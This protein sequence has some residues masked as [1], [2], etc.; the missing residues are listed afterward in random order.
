[1]QTF[2]LRHLDCPTC[3]VKIERGLNRMDG[4]MDAAIDFA[5]LTLRVSAGDPRRIIDAVGRIDPAVAVIPRA[6]HATPPSSPAPP[7][8]RRGIFLLTAAT[9]LFVVLLAGETL[10]A[11]G[12]LVVLQ[13]SVVLAAY[14]LAGWN[15]WRGA[16]HTIR[17]RIFFDENVL[18]VIATVGALIIGAHAEAVG[19]MIF[20]KAGELL[21]ERVLSRSRRA[22]R[23][24]LA[25]RPDLAVR[26][27]PA[28]PVAV[29]PET[30]NIGE[31]ILV[32]TGE[33][34]PL[35]GDVLTGR[36]QVDT[37]PLTGESRPR[38]VAPGD[39]VMAGQINRTGLLTVRVTRPF[40]QSSIARMMDLVENAVARK[41][42]TEQF[43]T[44]FA[45]YYTPAVVFAAA[46][47]A[48][49]PPLIWGGSFHAWLYRALVL[50]VISCPCALV[51]SIPLG[52]FGGIGN[53]S[54]QGIFFKGASFMDALA[55]LKTVVFD[56][57]GTLT[58]GVF[59]V[60]QVV[61]LNGY[62]GAQLL[63]FAAAAEYHA[64]H[65][66]AHSILT[67]FENAGG[68]LNSDHITA[69]TEL[70]GQGVRAA[71]QGRT[72]M[73]G[74]D[75][76]LHLRQIPHGRCDFD[77]TVAHIAVDDEYVGY[78]L[79]G[80][81]VKDD[82]R[83]AITALRRVGVDHIVML[84]GDNACAAQAVARQL[85]LDG[86]HADLLPEGKVARFDRIHDQRRHFG[87]IA[88]VGD[89]INDA[90][91][92]A[93]ADVGMAMGVLG[94]DAAIETADVVLMD[95]SPVK[96]AEAVGVAKST[97]A[98]VWQN[99]IL[100]FAVKA[101]FITFGAFGLATMWEAVFADVGTALLAVVNTTRAMGGWG[102]SK[103]AD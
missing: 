96:V 66:I 95:D 1:M 103:A 17:A 84:T 94:A 8:N 88:F 52:Y 78:I 98:I 82:A 64:S 41:A 51:V 38:A 83:Q 61:G 23:S 20:Y 42:R 37:S 62:S 46:A 36:S 67:A 57:T 53:A 89:G 9:L 73:V 59:S 5:T 33:K 47:I 2:D 79:I 99:I 4:V 13:W 68:R 87:R 102:G 30:V 24:V 100:A 65:P 19:V 49:A 58:R 69:H 70:A 7:L 32:K 3:A 35:D 97:R 25:A 48:L 18:M 60:N 77:T 10:F 21:Q 85:G 91:V 56:K 63:E 50:L 86:F 6:M 12:H 31:T 11:R 76:L 22:I 74:N 39:A 27:T 80:D 29:A 81:Q 44:T 72:I 75:Q 93:R 14:L 34:V 54:R 90:P 45:R 26:M 43:I 55:G 28:G 40:A 16:L 101:V 92:I 15:V 71:Y